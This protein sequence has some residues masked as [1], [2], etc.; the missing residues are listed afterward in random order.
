MGIWFDSI[1]QP[2]YCYTITMWVFFFLTIVSWYSLKSGTVKSPDILYCT[3]LFLVILSFFVCLIFRMRLSIVLLHFVLIHFVKPFLG[4]LLLFGRWWW[5]W[6]RTG[7]G[8]EE[9]QK[10]GLGGMDGE[11]NAISWEPRPNQRPTCLTVPTCAERSALALEPIPHSPSP[12][13][14]SNLQVSW[15]IQ[16]N[17]IKGL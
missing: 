9:K 15:H 2:L 14:S 5:W 17:G 1:G 6:R 7:S 3:G 11:E 10:E 12:S 16:D 4:D 8:R 13:C